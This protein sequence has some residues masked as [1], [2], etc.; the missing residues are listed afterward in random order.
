MKPSALKTM[1]FDD[2]LSLR[3]EIDSVLASRI[4]DEKRA[5]EAKLTKL[6]QLS[7]TSKPSALRHLSTSRAQSG[8]V[9][10]SKVPP[11]FYNPDNPSEMWSGR[12]LRPRW[13]VAALAAG[14]SLEDMVL[15]DDSGL[16]K[17]QEAKLP[18]KTRA[19]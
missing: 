16:P 3:A 10:G 5:L 1:S 6:G 13:M 8:P 17:V 11:R 14:R 7:D 9:K 15:D 2:L 19:K 12:G 4:D 18:K